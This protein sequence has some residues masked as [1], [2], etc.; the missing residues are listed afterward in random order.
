MIKIR[1]LFRTQISKLNILVKRVN[2]FQEKAPSQ[3]LEKV[4]NT[5]LTMVTETE[6]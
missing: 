2:G 4:L 3:M 6:G 5:P 1:G